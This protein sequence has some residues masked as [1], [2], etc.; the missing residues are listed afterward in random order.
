M[1]LRSLY[2]DEDFRNVRKPLR[3]GFTALVNLEELVSVRDELYLNVD[4]R[5][6]E[7]AEIWATCWP[8]LRRLSL[9]NV[10]LNLDTGFLEHLAGVPLLESVVFTRPDGLYEWY[11]PTTWRMPYSA[12]DIKAAWL[13]ALSA[14][15]YNGGLKRRK[16]LSIMFVSMP[17]QIPI[18]D[19]H[20][21]SWEKIDPE[22]LICVKFAGALAPSSPLFEQ[23]R[24]V[25]DFVRGLALDGTLFDANMGERMDLHTIY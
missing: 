24:G 21:E 3:D 23:T 1:P 8:K 25:Q 16:D 5:G 20:E 2:P 19:E 6:R 14:N 7:E 12:I 13:D 4:E 17:E 9:Y 10:D 15:A 11:D 22:G 18:F